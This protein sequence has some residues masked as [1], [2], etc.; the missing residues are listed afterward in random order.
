MLVALVPQGK[1]GVIAPYTRD[2]TRIN[3]LLEKGRG[4]PTVDQTVTLNQQKLVDL[5]Q[6]LKP[7]SEGD[8]DSL[9]D[10]VKTRNPSTDLNTQV[11]KNAYNLATEFSRDDKSRTEFSLKAIESMASFMSKEDPNDHVVI[12]YVSGGFNADPG[13]RYFDLID[14]V[15]EGRGMKG[16]M[17]TYTV[18]T[19]GRHEETFDMQ[20][21]VKESIGKLNRYNATLYAVNTRG[22][23]LVSTNSG[24]TAEFN[25]NES[26]YIQDF[27]DSLRQMAEETGGLAFQNSQ[28]FKVGFDKILTD[29]DHQYTICYQAPQHS[30]KDQYHR[31][32]VVAKKSGIQIRNRH[33]YID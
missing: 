11:L 2:V 24:P 9:E 28:N 13:R 21:L 4:N 18:R 8:V 26:Q 25:T 23:A 16:N 6:Q 17:M 22:M 27:Q 20:H 7:E 3:T 1:L 33:G 32:R 29:L 31:I 30:K 19:G 10:L 5:L 14:R 12:L 15:A